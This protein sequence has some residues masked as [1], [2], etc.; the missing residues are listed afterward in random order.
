MHG[1]HMELPALVFAVGRG[2][3]H[4]DASDMIPGHQ[5]PARPAHQGQVAILPRVDAR[6]SSARGKDA[7]AREAGAPSHRNTPE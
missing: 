6:Y 2:M 1:D 3:L 7:Y 5:A 4:P